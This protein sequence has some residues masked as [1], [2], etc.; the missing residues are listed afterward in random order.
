MHRDAFL[1]SVADHMPWCSK[2]ESA[3]QWFCSC[4]TVFDFFSFSVGFFSES[5]QVWVSFSKVRFEKLC[6]PVFACFS[7][8]H[9][10]TRREKCMNFFLFSF[11]VCSSLIKFKFRELGTVFKF[12][13][14]CVCS[15][16]STVWKLGA[17]NLD[18]TELWLWKGPT[19]C[20]FHFWG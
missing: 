8:G 16:D 5:W 12:A 13:S 14:I 1:F 9:S 15:I 4:R 11:F 17:Q 7:E 20:P 2:S 18:C 19:L 3:F 10:G 6:L